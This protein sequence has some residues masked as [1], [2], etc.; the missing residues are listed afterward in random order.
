M[1]TFRARAGVND[2]NGG[3]THWVDALV[4]TGATYSVLP[5]SMLRE[6]LGMEPTTHLTFTFA[7]GE[8]RELPVGEA[9]FCVGGREG[10]SKV[11][12]GPENQYLLGAT[13]LQEL[14]LIAD[15]S[16][17]RLVPAPTLLI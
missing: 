13:A 7:T 11:V 9:R 1:G 16:A 6:R 5:A 4:D 15:T 12:F 14:A 8:R 10:A 17:H 3:A 2:G